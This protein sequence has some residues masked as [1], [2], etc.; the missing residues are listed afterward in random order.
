MPP[1]LEKLLLAETYHSTFAYVFEGSADFRGASE[2][3]EV[4]TEVVTAGD[5][6]HVNG[7]TGNRSVILFDTGDEVVVR[8]GEHGVRFLLVSGEPLREPVAWRGP[9]VMNSDEEIRKAFAEL[10]EG[11]FIKR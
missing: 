8:A 9:I 3:R 4:A 6:S 1:A 2:P 7:E 10:R 5:G 11:T